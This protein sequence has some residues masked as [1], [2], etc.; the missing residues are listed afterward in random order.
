MANYAI[1]LLGWL[2][3]WLLCYLPWSN[4]FKIIVGWPFSL[5]YFVVKV[6]SGHLI[7]F[8]NSESPN[9]ASE[10][11]SVLINPIFAITPLI[12]S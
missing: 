8:E 1:G 11:S 9:H 2:L 10:F 3:L 7:G 12:G 4:R 5:T 6:R